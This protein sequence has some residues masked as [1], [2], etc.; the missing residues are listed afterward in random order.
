[1]QNDEEQAGG[2]ESLQLQENRVLAGE[3]EKLDALA[4]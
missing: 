2:N 4:Q 3:V 1:V